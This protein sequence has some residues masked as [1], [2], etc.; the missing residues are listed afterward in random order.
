MN[1]AAP[2]TWPE[3]PTFRLDELSDPDARGFYVGEG[4]WPFRGFIVRKGKNI[5]AYANIC[6]HRRHPLDFLPDAFLVEDGELVRCASHGALF[7]PE[8]G[9]CVM[10]PCQG[11]SLMKLTFR[12][13]SAG[14]IFVTAPASL[15]D[16]G[17]IIGTG[18]NMQSDAGPDTN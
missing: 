7:N 9:V 8:T 3:W 6:P 11:E 15:R 14:T 2:E 1:S 17:P 10:G 13:D 12:L 16:A 5:F 18:F 4:D